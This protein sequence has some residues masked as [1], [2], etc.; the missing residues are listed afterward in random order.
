MAFE[1]GDSIC[2]NCPD[3]DVSVIKGSKDD[4]VVH[5]CQIV[6]EA[7]EHLLGHALQGRRL[8]GPGAHSLVFARRNYVVRSV[9]SHHFYSCYHVVVRCWLHK[10]VTVVPKEKLV[11]FLLALGV[12][13]SDAK[14]K[15]LS[16]LLETFGD[17]GD[18]RKF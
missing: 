17:S 14:N 3:S 1:G 8:H 6:Y 16:K 12:V 15:C 2:G 4:R 13:D 18:T 7:G 9:H 10:R 5:L 11:V